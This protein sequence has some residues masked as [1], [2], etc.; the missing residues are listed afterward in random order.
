MRDPK[1]AYVNADD[2]PHYIRPGRPGYTLCKHMVVLVP[3]VQ[4]VTPAKVCPDCGQRAAHGAPYVHAD[5]AFTVV[6]PLCGAEETPEPDLTLPE[7]KEQRR[8]KWG[9][10]RTDANCGGAGQK[11]EAGD[12]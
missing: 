11:P 10:Y 6:C 3:E 8:N 5:V 7:H 9:V 12:A 2:L 4:P 1:Y